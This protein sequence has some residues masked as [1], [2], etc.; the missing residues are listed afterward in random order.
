MKPFWT[1]ILTNLNFEQEIYNKL[2]II[3]MYLYIIKKYNK[4]NNNFYNEFDT[5]KWLNFIQHYDKY[6]LKKTFLSELESPI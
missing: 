6:L 1:K 4:S 3:V 2:I 5:C